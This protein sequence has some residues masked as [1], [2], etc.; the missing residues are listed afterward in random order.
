[1]FS[2]R[3]LV[4]VKNVRYGIAVRRELAAYLGQPMPGATLVLLSAERKLDAKDPLAAAMASKG[5][6]VGFKALKEPEAVSR[7]REE[8]KR[9][10]LALSEEAAQRLVEE[11]G[12]EWGVLKAEL[13]KLRLFVRGRDRADADDVGACLGFRKEAN[14]FDFPR[15]LQSRD[16]RRA[17]GLLAR[18]LEEDAD[19]FR[20]VYQISGTLNKQLKAKRLLKAGRGP[21]AVFRELRLNAY[22]DKDYLA[23]L[24]RIS[25]DRLRRDLRACL[26]TEVA[27]KSRSWLDPAV[28]L[29]ALVAAICRASPAKPKA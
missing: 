11:A 9:S 14:P 28:E 4:L 25:E 26:E 3:R 5:G 10:G 18:M 20:L 6:A 13:E 22:Y 23:Q 17:V 15:A 29:T 7:L 16:A 2:E 24:A 21:D 27:L 19:H 1:M 12:T 8:A